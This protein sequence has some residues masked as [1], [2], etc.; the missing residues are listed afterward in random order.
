M[1]STPRAHHTAQCAMLSAGGQ[2]SASPPILPPRNLELGLKHFFP[3][4]VYKENNT[5]ISNVLLFLK[6]AQEKASER[7]VA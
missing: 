6:S 2:P 5:R 1:P 4:T 3:D 7:K